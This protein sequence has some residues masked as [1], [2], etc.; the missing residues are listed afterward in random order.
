MEGGDFEEYTHILT[1][2]EGNILIDGEGNT[3]IEPP[4]QVRQVF[5][6]PFG[7]IMWVLL[8][9]GAL[10]LVSS[11]LLATLPSTSHPH[12]ALQ[13]VSGATLNLGTESIAFGVIMAISRWFFRRV[14]EWP[15][16]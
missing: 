13:W 16:L 6:P 12:P 2:G 4:Q 9:F 14:D 11:F 5:L 15:E 7:K 1:D 10:L 3:L 8:V